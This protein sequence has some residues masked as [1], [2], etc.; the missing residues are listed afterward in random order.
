[1]DWANEAD[2][3]L[4]RLSVTHE[5][6]FYDMAHEIVAEELADFSQWL[7]NTLPISNSREVLHHD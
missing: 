2:A 1:M 5:T 4:N 3:W 7:T 6:H